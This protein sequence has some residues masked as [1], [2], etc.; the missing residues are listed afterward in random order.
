MPNRSNRTVGDGIRRRF[1]SQ[2][3]NVLNK[4]LLF[5]GKLSWKRLQ[6]AGSYGIR[7]GF[8][9]NDASSLLSNRI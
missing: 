5:A 3:Y 9:E 2:N 6:T 8:H 4:V 1:N 7:V